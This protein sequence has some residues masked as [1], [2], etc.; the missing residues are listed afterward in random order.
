L[1]LCILLGLTVP[2]EI[3]AGWLSYKHLPFTWLYHIYVIFEYFLLSMF[4]LPA[5]SS[6]VKIFIW[7]SIPCFALISLS[8]SHWW[9]DFGGFP[10]A[11][12]NTEGVFIFIICTYIL[13]N[14]QVDRNV[15]ITRH[16]DFW[17]GTGLLVFFGGTFFSNGL[18]SYL[19]ALDRDQALEVFGM[20]NMPLNII[21][22]CCLITGLL[23]VKPPKFITRLF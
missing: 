21:L 7:G 13:F 16:P 17:I 14:L 8:I 10:G 1:P 2:T 23:C 12:I 11:N 4:F 18:Y 19:L 3:A 9:Y 15:K 5:A 6:R 20:V 22:Y